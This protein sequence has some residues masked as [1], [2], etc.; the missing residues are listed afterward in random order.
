M[1]KTKVMH[2]LK[3]ICSFLDDRH[4]F[5]FSESE[6]LLDKG[7]DL[8]SSGVL[9]EDVEMFLIIEVSIEVDDIRMS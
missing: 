9:G 8:S 7:V 4:H 6:F 3:S 1:D 2:E 5:L